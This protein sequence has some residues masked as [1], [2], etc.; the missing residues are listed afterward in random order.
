[1]TRS[2]SE[3]PVIDIGPLV[4]ADRTAADNERTIARLGDACADV[5]F[6]YVINH[7]IPEADS[8]AA[9]AETKRFFALPLEAKMKIR[10]GITSQFRGFVPIGGEVT[11]GSS[12]WHE[13]VDL[14]PR[15]GRHASDFAAAV[16][17]RDTGRHPLD[18]P[19]QWPQSLP[20]FSTTMMRAWD[21][22]YE[23]G[24]R[25]AAGMALSLGLDEH[26][27]EPF[28]GPELC[29]LR[30][31]H[32]PP[33]GPPAADDGETAD[34][35][36]GFGAHVDYGFLT[37]LQQDEISGLEVRNS[38]GD[39]ISAPPVPGAFLVNI[40]E[41]MQRWTNDRYRA[42]WHRVL[43]PG[44]ADRYSIPFFFEPRFDARVEPLPVCCDAAN[45]PRYQPCEFG[46]YSMGRYATAYD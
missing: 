4:T 35:D 5:G 31:L 13:C 21:D 46:P 37:V 42:T 36:F 39:W 16:A 10:M 7:G 34:G 22:R 12:D 40:G 14:Q 19:G 24:G 41:M 30:L 1:M 15:W 23:L 26:F 28:S 17:V 29:D 20:S 8:A 11:G 27:F 38:E 2:F 3:I 6:F 32:Y 9:L 44:T 25:I 33:L 45:P 18:D 43:R